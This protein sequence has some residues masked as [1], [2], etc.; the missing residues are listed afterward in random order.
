[1]LQSRFTE[2]PLH[3]L[4]ILMSHSHS[5]YRD[6]VCNTLNRCELPILPTN[7]L[8]SLRLVGSLKSQVSFAEYRLFYRALL[9]K[10]STILSKFKVPTNRSHS[11]AVVECFESYDVANARTLLQNIASFIGLFCKRD[12]LVQV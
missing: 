12:R 4:Y 6:A 10:R 5:M 7:I 1:M 3:D 9:Q 8:R 11:I 2:C